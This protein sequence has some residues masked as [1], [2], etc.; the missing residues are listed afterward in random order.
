V[1]RVLIVEDND[2]NRYLARYLLEQAGF[3]VE[4]AVNGADGLARARAG[5]FHLVVLDIQMPE[6]D[7]YEVATALRADPRTARIPIVGVSSF[8]MAGDRDKAMRL[9]FAGYLEKPIDP[10][11]FAGELR[12]LMEAGP[13]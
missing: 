1:S 6:M 4:T 7:G 9:G 5:A 12:R 13:A 3:E 11:T 10:T 8:A 2:T